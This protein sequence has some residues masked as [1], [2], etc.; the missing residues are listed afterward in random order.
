MSPTRRRPRLG[1]LLT[2][3]AAGL[4]ALNAS[5][6]EFLLEDGVSPTHLAQLRA[7]VAWAVLVAV[8]LAVDPRRLRVARADVPHLAFLGVVGLALVQA[9]Y[10]LAISRLAIGV[11]VTLQFLGPI[12]LLLWLAVAHRRR[13]RPGLWGAVALSVAG[14]FLVVG[15]YRGG[16]LDAGG[17]LAALAAAVAL[18]V[19]LVASERAGRRHP[20]ATTLAWA[21]GFA[22]LFWLVVRPPWT[23]PWGE[24]ATPDHVALALAVALGGTLVPFGLE[25]AALR[26][27]PAARVAV[28]ATLE[29]VLAA[30]IAW[31]VH[32]QALAPVQALGAVLVVAA[33]AWVQTHPPTV[34]EAAPPIRGTRPEVVAMVDDP[35][36]P[37]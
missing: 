37:G 22:T 2:A 6:A 1:Y 29:P 21:L 25:V 28:V 18:A 32:G 26:H 24:L 4:F 31:P 23:F 30:L 19:Y 11:A 13:L 35:G 27:L 8:L 16:S 36:R 10:F 3:L 9:A 20:P 15:A 34:Q 14:C 17:V 33:V 7:T 12:L 5:L